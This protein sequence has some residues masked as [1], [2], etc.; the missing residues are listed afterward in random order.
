M[1]EFIPGDGVGSIRALHPTRKLRRVVV[2][3]VVC[4]YAFKLLLMTF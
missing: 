2:S 1:T 3:L 4:F